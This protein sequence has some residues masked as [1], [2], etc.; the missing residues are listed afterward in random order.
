LRQRPYAFHVFQA[1]RRL[2]CA[3][4]ELPRLGKSTRLSDDPL[5]LTQ[6]P[7][8]A[9]APSTLAAFKP[10]NEQHPPRL[11]EY[12]LGLFGPQGPLPLHLTE[13]ARKRFRVAMNSYALASGGGRFPV[14]REIAERPESR[15]EMTD[16]DTR[17][18]VVEYVRKH[19]PLR[20]DA[21]S[22]VTVVRHEDAKR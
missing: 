17:T 6:E 15:L 1:L 16:I 13:Y 20:I 10:G 8:L 2:E 14:L 5:R 3:Y 21:G 9:F 18:A 11:S 12:F 4:R 22:G 19:N 7:S